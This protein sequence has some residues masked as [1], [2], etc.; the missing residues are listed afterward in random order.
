MVLPDQNVHQNAER[1][2]I[3]L[4]IVIN[5][6]NY[7]HRLHTDTILVTFKKRMKQYFNPLRRG[8]KKYFISFPKQLC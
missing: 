5:F 6:R 2:K 8:R 3:S 1:I 7:N 4:H